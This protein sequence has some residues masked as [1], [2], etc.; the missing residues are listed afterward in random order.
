MKLKNL[1]MKKWIK[2]LIAV[3][4]TP[5]LLFAI[6]LLTYIIMNRQ[7]VI[8][9]FQL[10]N[11]GAENKI[12]IASQGSDF[13]DALVSGIIESLKKQSI[14]IKVMDVSGLSEVTEEMWQALIIINTC[15]VGKMHSEVRHYL[16]Q[17]KELNKVILFTTSGSGNWK[18]E[19]SSIDSISSASKMTQ[20][21]LA[22]THIVDN[23][24]KILGSISKG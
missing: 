13:K 15:E 1:K 21:D 20:V 6:L 12:L 19:D 5:V 3:I 9:P 7:E 14:Y 4:T 16:F 2:V 22:V 11:S 18:P 24:N 17:A 23:L 10:G 8:E